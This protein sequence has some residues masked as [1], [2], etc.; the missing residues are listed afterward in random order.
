[1][2][3]KDQ[4]KWDAKY[5][6]KEYITGK[7]PCSW[8]IDNAE[9]LNGEGRALD[10]TIGEGRNATYLAVLGYNVL[11]LDISRVGIDKAHALANEKGVSFSTEI[12]DLDNYELPLKE[13]DLIICF[14]FLERRLFQGIRDALKPNGILFYETFNVDY[15]KYSNFKEEWV[16][17]SGELLRE[18]AQFLILRYREL[19][20]GEK[21]VASIVCQK[22]G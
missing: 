15:L 1:M 16:L 17:K 12:V 9:L 21:G 3:Q 7:E 6:S 22:M 4:E 18:F 11:G 2:G 13:F 19:D 20:N 5:R 8:L 10:L 14:N